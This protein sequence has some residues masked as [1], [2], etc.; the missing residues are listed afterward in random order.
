M[1]SESAIV[2]C[3]SV[4]RWLSIN[5]SLISVSQNSDPPIIEPGLLSV[6]VSQSLLSVSQ[7]LCPVIRESE[8][9]ISES[10]PAISESEPAISESRPVITYQ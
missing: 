1:D 7:G 8:P 2:I 5:K 9:V 6:S 4:P 10:G 3:E